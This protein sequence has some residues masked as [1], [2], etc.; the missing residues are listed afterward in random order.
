MGSESAASA[1][2][3]TSAGSGGA[4]W[5]YPGDGYNEQLWYR[6]FNPRP[7]WWLKSETPLTEQ[8][9]LR[10]VYGVAVLSFGV[11]GACQLYPGLSSEE[12]AEP[13]GNQVQPAPGLLH[14]RDAAN[15]EYAVAMLPACANLLTP[16]PPPTQNNSARSLLLTR[17]HLARGT[18]GPR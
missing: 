11:V 10:R 18:T 2:S 16:P 6:V 5:P 12:D 14:P 3:S 7:W 4:S 15:T 13:T 1:S 8:A 17:V 9:R